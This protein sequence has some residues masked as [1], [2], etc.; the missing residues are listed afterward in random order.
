MLTVNSDYVDSPSVF[1]DDAGMKSSPT[2][3]R[4]ASAF[5]ATVDAW[6]GTLGS[7]A[8][9]AAYR[10][11]LAA[12]GR[13]CALEGVPPLRVDTATV[14]AYLLAQEATGRRPVTVRRHR[15]A[16]SSF[17]RF[18]VAA[19]LARSNPVT[20]TVRPALG[21]REETSATPVLSQLDVDVC[22]E[23]AASLDPRLEALVGLIVFDGL[24]L[25]EALAVD[26][27]DI[28]GRPP[29][30]SIGIRR[31]GT[32]RRLTLDPRSARAVRRCAAGR[33][34]QP[35]FTSAGR[36]SAIGGGLRLTRFGAGNLIKQLAPAA[37]QAFSANALR[38]FHIASGHASGLDLDAVRARAGL[39]DVRT[40]KRHLG[41]A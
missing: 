8:T 13:W 18:A 19:E 41:Q 40:V 9:R 28:R 32:T 31:R 1:G 3:A 38:R 30:V 21:A 14:A 26:V 39:G 29:K 22:L 33:S 11:D 25:G 12:F 36:V 10:S 16:L 23:A 4:G 17:Y 15:S 37:G 6:S 7:A 2:T 34:G 20:D 5:G 24:K 27:D 35:L